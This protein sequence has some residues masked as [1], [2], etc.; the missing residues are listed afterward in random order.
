MLGGG[1]WIRGENKGDG[2]VAVQVM[3]GDVMKVLVML[4]V[5]EVLGGIGVNGGMV[6]EVVVVM[7]V[8]V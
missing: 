6:K 7:W 8:M 3:D 4:G 2:K 1:G 5:V